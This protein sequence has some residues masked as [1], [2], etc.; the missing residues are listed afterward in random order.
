MILE[1]LGA[2]YIYIYIYIYTPSLY[3][4]VKNEIKSNKINRGGLCQYV[5]RHK[6]WA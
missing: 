5:N 2:V 1:S 6:E 3:Q 4:L